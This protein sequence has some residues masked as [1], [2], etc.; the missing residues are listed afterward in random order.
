MDD[1]TSPPRW[2][3]KLGFWVI[4]G[5]LATAFPEVV[6]G[7]MPWPFFNGW[8]ILI[9]TPLYALH[10]IVLITIVVRLRAL[11]W[12]G[13]LFAGALFGL[14][15]GYLTKVLFNPYFAENLAG[16]FLGLAWHH[17]ALL[18]LWWHPI[19][20]FI[21]P[22][23]VAE[24]FLTSSRG[25][26]D[27]LP[28][29][30][31]RW[32]ATPRRTAVTAAAAGVICALFTVVGPP[33][34][35]HGF[36]IA[37]VNTGL[38]VALMLVWT[39]RTRRRYPLHTLLPGKKGLAVMIALLAVMYGLMGPLLLRDKLPSVDGHLSILAC[40][41]VFTLLLLR[42]RNTS[43]PVLQE[44]LALAM[45]PPY[46][47]MALF[48]AVYVITAPVAKAVLGQALMV[49]FLVNWLAADTVGVVLYAKAIHA[50]LRRTRKPDSVQEAAPSHA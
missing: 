8:G 18:V 11:T 50:T 22:L 6:S 34:A 39:K 21:V 9:T 36:A 46:R 20:A 5:M 30:V 41:M 43:R 44:D 17:A 49:M 3:T 26:R 31:R 2:R 7:A 45:P 38:L 32:V 10:A 29:R 19:M 12:P 47:A 35:A 42:C 14:Y 28:Q 25:V 4:L 16:S 40:Y 23:L 13:L 33:T 27:A 48:C 1:A 24:T 15:E 37:A